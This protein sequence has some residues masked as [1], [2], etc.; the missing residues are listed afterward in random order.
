MA[1]PS[2]DGG[3]GHLAIVISTEEDGY[4]CGRQYVFSFE[5]EAALSGWVLVIKSQAAVCRRLYSKKTRVQHAQVPSPSSP[6]SSPW[7]RRCV[8]VCVCVCV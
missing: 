4:N 2:D 5:G 3:H 7:R 8:C 1:Q 6:T